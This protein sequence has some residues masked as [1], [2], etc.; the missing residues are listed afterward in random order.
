MNL[1][2]ERATHTF[3]R[4]GFAAV[5]YFFEM[6]APARAGIEAP[7][8]AGLRVVTYD[9]QYEKT[10]YD[11]HMEAFSDHWGYQ[12]R[13]FDS[14]TG[15]T[16]R[17]ETFRSDL[18]RIA[19]DGD[20]I[21]GY[22]LSYDDADEDRAYVGQVGTRRP[23]RRRGLAGGLLAD[24]LGAAAA[25]GKGHVYLGVDADSPTGAVGVYERV[26]FEVETRAVAYH[27]PVD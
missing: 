18:S 3:E 22:V 16:T 7:I 21:A 1:A 20:E 4:F 10:L 9:P 19:F 6:V 13:D 24:V 26:G 15:F 5:R 27:K 2:D 17:N 25:T 11:A 8:P 23:W 14:W 12:K